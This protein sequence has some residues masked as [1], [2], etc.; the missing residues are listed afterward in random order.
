MLSSKLKSPSE[1]NDLDSLSCGMN[2]RPFGVSKPKSFT[3]VGK[4][5]NYQSYTV[6]LHIPVLHRTGILGPYQYGQALSEEANYREKMFKLG[7]G[8]KYRQGHLKSARKFALLPRVHIFC[9]EKCLEI[10]LFIHFFL[11]IAL[12]DRSDAAPETGDS[13]YHTSNNF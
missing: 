5:G 4:A 1:C 8:S 3:T 13:S 11:A 12:Q 6:V 7:S 2:D 9:S 10:T